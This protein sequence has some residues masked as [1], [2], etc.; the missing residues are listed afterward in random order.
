LKKAFNNYFVV[1]FPLIFVLFP[2]IVTTISA[3]TATME[4]GAHNIQREWTGVWL[5]CT[6]FVPY[7]LF[8]PTMIAWYGAYALARS[9]DLKWGNRPDSTESSSEVVD[10]ARILVGLAVT[11]NLLIAS[12]SIYMTAN[13]NYVAGMVVVVL[14][15]SLF[16][17]MISLVYFSYNLLTVIPRFCCKSR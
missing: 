15:C 12:V 4:K 7:Y 11:V 17:M 14:F 3:V 1:F 10:T 16:E 8:L 13:Q 6:R 9:A 5:M 2:I